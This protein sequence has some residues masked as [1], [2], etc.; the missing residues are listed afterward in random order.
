[1]NGLNGVEVM[2]TDCYPKRVERVEDIGMNYPRGCR[3]SI[4]FIT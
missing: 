4:Y 2:I 1:V 3:V